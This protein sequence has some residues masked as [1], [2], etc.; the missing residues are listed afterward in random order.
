M[1]LSHYHSLPPN[2]YNEYL[3]V[4]SLLSG[5]GYLFNLIIMMKETDLVYPLTITDLDEK[6]YA[7]K[8]Q[9]GRDRTEWFDV[10]LQTEK[11][12][13]YNNLFKEVFTLYNDFYIQQEYAEFIDGESPYI[14]Y[15]NTRII[16]ID[17]DKEKEKLRVKVET[18]KLKNPDNGNDIQSF[19]DM[20]EVWSHKEDYK[21]GGMHKGLNQ[22]IANTYP[23][24]V[25]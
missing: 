12:E 9:L 16:V 15:E 18:V 25:I 6:Y 3:K 4:K 5:M 11:L 24:W 21:Y 1:L 7:M 23:H 2:R 19:G 22:Y 17:V 8:M 20:F 14:V 10:E 13:L